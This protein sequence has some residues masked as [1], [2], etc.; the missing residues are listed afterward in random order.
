[1]PH[2]LGTPDIAWT[3]RALSFPLYVL[4]AISLSPVLQT[5]QIHR[6]QALGPVLHRLN[7]VPPIPKAFLGLPFFPRVRDK[8]QAPAPSTSWPRSLFL[9]VLA[10]AP[11]RGL[12]DLPV[13]FL[14]FPGLGLSWGWM[15]ADRHTCA[16]KAPP[17]PGEQ[18]VPHP[19]TPTPTL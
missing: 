18:D 17:R 15:R 16:G 14:M 1:M 11:G 12:L 19:P 9:I 10:L 7:L 13:L 3:S 2:K 6:L 5:Q 4:P 8:V